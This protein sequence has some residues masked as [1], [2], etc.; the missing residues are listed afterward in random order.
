MRRTFGPSTGSIFHDLPRSF[1]RTFRKRRGRGVRTSSWTRGRLLSRPAIVARCRRM[2][3]WRD[4]AASDCGFVSVGWETETNSSEL[5]FSHQF[6][7]VE[8]LRVPVPPVEE[9]PSV[10][11]RASSLGK[12]ILEHLA[13][14]RAWWCLRCGNSLT[15]VSTH[16]SGSGAGIFLNIMGEPFAVA[17]GNSRAP[18]QGTSFTFAI[19]GRQRG[20]RQSL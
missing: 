2:P 17:H 18:G 8:G 6:N 3:C 5:R 16:G 19:L 20:C 12:E 10:H 1:T 13:L 9:Q 7:V 11:G 4:R 14:H 15:M